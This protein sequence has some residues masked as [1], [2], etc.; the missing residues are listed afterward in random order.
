MPPL[1]TVF[2][3][4]RQI[5][6]SAIRTLANTHSDAASSFAPTALDMLTFQTLP[7]PIHAP[8]RQPGTRA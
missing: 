8:I 4:A 7:R 6:L 1:D 3:R 2:T 5:S